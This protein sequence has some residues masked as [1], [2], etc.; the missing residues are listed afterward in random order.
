MIKILKYLN[1]LPIR[2]TMNHYQMFGESSNDLKDNSLNNVE[3]WEALRDNHPHFSISDN[4]DEW[5]NASE[6]KVVKDGQDGGLLK[7]AEQLVIFLRRENIKILFSVGVGGAGL[8][9]Q[10]KK[11]MP[12]LRLICSEYE[13]KTVKKLKK[14]FVESE[15]V[16]AFDIINGDWVDVQSRY[17]SQDKS[18]VLIY[19][20]DAG[21]SNQEWRQIFESMSNAGVS[22]V[23]YIP[24]TMLSILSIWNRKYRE[25]KWYITRRPVSFA[26]YL[27]TKKVF[28]SFWAHYYK[29]ECITF[30]GLKSFWLKSD[31]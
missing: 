20:L 15:D 14:V 19:R 4:R 5:I 3:S 10:I 7:R 9:Y 24:T 27:R 6:L 28:Q 25:V 21:F 18:A 1:T 11:R 12:E 23:V 13:P 16:F 30:G 29:E 17:L 31:K 22:N 2:F 26:G 8:E